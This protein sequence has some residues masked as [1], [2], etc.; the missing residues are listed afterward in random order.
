MAQD[1]C[2]I[3]IIGAGPAGCCCAYFLENNNNIKV[4][5]IDYSSPLRTILATGGGRCNLANSEFDFKELAKNYPRGEKFLL[6]V[7]SKFATAETLELFENLGIETY[8]QNNGRI[9]P[10]SNSAKEVRDKFLENIKA[11]KFIREKALRIEKNGR[12]FKV[13]TD[14]N[15]YIFDKLIF[16]VGGHAGYE[17]IKRIGVTIIEPKPSLVGLVTKEKLSDLMG[18]SVQNV[19]NNET[20]MS[21]DIL[22][23]HFGISGPLVYKVSSV[24]ARE[25]FPYTLSFDLVPDLDNFQDILNNNPH[26]FIK[27]ILSDYLPNRFAEY[28]LKCLNINPELKSHRIDG[29]TRDK[30]LDKIHNF[31]LNIKSTKAD[32]E[33]VTAG[34]VSLDKINSK[35]MESKE[36]E[37]LY[38]CGEVID[39][40]GF[41]GGF[42]LQNCWSTAYVCTEGLKDNLQYL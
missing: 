11:A 34:G 3:G 5:L 2:N 29:K 33:T 7:F 14:M 31:S 28:I 35:T 17:M 25:S 8:S 37:G 13:V 30:I 24:K 12:K 16:S 27:N 18:I 38:F 23:T 21:G 26:K 10:I 40:D 20:G 41:C 4:S 39:V 1:L 6:S 19:T 9:F 15:S 32:G 36:V 42:N 22:F